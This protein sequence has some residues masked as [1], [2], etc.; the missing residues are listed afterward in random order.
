MTKRLYWEQ[1]VRQAAGRG[2]V[3]GAAAARPPSFGCLLQLGSGPAQLPAFL[4]GGGG[5]EFPPR[6]SGVSHLRL[7]H[8][9]QHV[10][11]GTW[12]R[13]LGEACSK[14]AA[15][16]HKTA[17][18]SSLSGARPLCE[19]QI[20]SRAR[21]MDVPRPCRCATGWEGRA[22]RRLPPVGF[23]WGKRCAEPLCSH[24]AAQVRGE[25]VRG[26]DPQ[27]RETGLAP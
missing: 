14:S 19:G 18:C 24:R 22:S 11:T 21:V 6:S 13:G 17:A 16:L 3:P 7:S 27:P 9:P 4:G 1:P 26:M 5:G 23:H 8:T 20:N 15:P 10:V 2:T 25:S 12:K